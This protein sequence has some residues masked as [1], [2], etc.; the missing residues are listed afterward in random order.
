MAN[1]SDFFCECDGCEADHEPGDCPKAAEVEIA[2][3]ASAYAGELRCLECMFQ[4]IGLGFTALPVKM[5]HA[6]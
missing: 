5:L 4:M 3:D 6:V 1:P 2:E